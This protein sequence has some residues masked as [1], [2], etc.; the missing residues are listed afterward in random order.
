MKPAKQEFD[1]HSNKGPISAALSDEHQRNWS[2][3]QW[4]RQMKKPG[5]HY[6]PTR[7]HLNFEIVKGGKIQPIDTNKSLPERFRERCEALGIKNPNF[8]TDPKTGERLE[9]GRIT[10]VNII[11]G[12]S[13]E[14]MHEIAF[15][16]QE[17]DT[18]P[19]APNPGIHRT[20]DIERWAKDMYN[21]ACLKW[22]EENILGFY[23]HLDELNPHAHCTIMPVATI[24]GKPGI[25]FNNAFWNQRNKGEVLRGL[26]DELAEFNRKW[27]LERGDSVAMTGAVHKDKNE[28]IR[29]QQQNAATI[30]QQQ[31]AIKGLTT[32]IDHL[33]QKRNELSQ[34]ISQMQLVSETDKEQYEQQIAQL[35][36]QLD[37][38]EK[39]L[40]EKNNK[41][42]DAR[43][44]LRQLKNELAESKRLKER[45]DAANKRALY[46]PSAVRNTLSSLLFDS[47]T[48][49]VA[50]VLS[51][52][53]TT[54]PE[55]EM[56]TNSLAGAVLDK[57]N[58][59]ITCAV[60]LFVGAVDEATNIVQSNGGGGTTSDLPWRDPDDD[61][62]R[63]YAKCLNAAYKMM[64]PAKGYKP[65]K[66]K[67]SGGY[68]Y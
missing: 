41:L 23:V 47:F 63:W 50:D 55:D 44:K 27:G 53:R 18:T 1:I 14:R 16:D 67:K 5:N 65:A 49:S 45:I 61:D 20:K 26:H 35:R 28:W 57:G 6:D 13:R 66:T 12:G 10:S 32:M 43:L 2:K 42:N 25:S 22:G 31:K 60:C 7:A 51:Q 40:T 34:A 21:F 17:I 8:K 46:A 9:T 68:G 11:F 15:G 24:R 59:I 19:N 39:A 38:V 58:E 37:A 62:K 33:T 3:E 30:R 64:R 54:M 48:N 36:S 4:E 29:E 52:I 56:I